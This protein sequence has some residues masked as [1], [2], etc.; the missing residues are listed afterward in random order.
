MTDACDQSAG[1][2]CV[3]GARHGPTDRVGEVVEC[4]RR[5]CAE[6]EEQH[7]RGTEPGAGRD[8]DRHRRPV[9]FLRVGCCDRRCRGMS[10]RVRPSRR[11]RMAPPSDRCRGRPSVDGGR[12]A[13][14]RPDSAATNGAAA[15]RSGSTA[16]SGSSVSASGAECPCDLGGHGRLDERREHP[17]G[18]DIVREREEPPTSIGRFG[19][20]RR[21]QRR[22]TPCFVAEGNHPQTGRGARQQRSQRRLASAPEV[23]VVDDEQREVSRQRSDV[24]RPTAVPRQRCRREL[25]S[26]IGPSS[27]RRWGNHFAQSHSASRSGAVAI[28]TSRSAGLWAVVASTRIGASQCGTFGFVPRRSPP[29]AR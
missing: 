16:G 6:V 22:C 1:I 15:A 28:T 3:P 14:G 9:G 2:D 8:G 19:D 17:V 27:T 24:G 7:R 25:A 21:A 10:G 29:L 11:H 5:R 4:R 20:Q 23:R 26:T 13:S 18:V 12:R